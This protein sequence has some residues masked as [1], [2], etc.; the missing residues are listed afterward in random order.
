MNETVSEKTRGWTRR[1]DARPGEILEAALEIFAEKGFAATRMED[2]AARAGVTKGTIYLYYPGKEELFKSLARET[3]GKAL[4][5]ATRNMAGIAGN[6]RQSLIRALTAIASFLND[7][8]RA[9]LPKII[10]A[11]SGNFPELAVFWRQEVVDTAFSLLCGIYDRGVELGQFRQLPREDVVRLCV[12]PII[13]SIIWR[14]TFNDT[15]DSARFFESHLDTLYH[16]L[17][18]PEASN[19]PQQ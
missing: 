9:T 3:V 4:A 7:G 8:R 6:P 14:T 16:G 19:A 13:L 10:I 18:T 2:I 12:A 15:F 5:S 1:K 17:L 11:E